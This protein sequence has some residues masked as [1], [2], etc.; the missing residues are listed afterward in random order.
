MDDLAPPASMYASATSIAAARAAKQVPPKQASRA[1]YEDAG[2]SVWGGDVGAS[3]G[4][5]GIGDHMP[6]D[7][8]HGVADAK[9]PVVAVLSCIDYRIIAGIATELNARGL[10]GRWDQFTMA[11]AALGAQQTKF[12]SWSQTFWDH[13]GLVRTMHEVRTLVIVNHLDCG[14]AHLLHPH[15]QGDMA[16]ERVVHADSMAKLEAAVK[17]KYPDMR[18]ETLLVDMTGSVVGAD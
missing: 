16:A 3:G 11:G 18:V 10:E 17:A 1:F 6:E 13:L 5:G 9:Q 12:P 7:V 8:A 14:C 15:T 2:S 4:A